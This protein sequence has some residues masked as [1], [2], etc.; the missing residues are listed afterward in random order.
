MTHPRSLPGAALAA[1]L[2]ALL[3]STFTGCS[4]TQL[5]VL[6]EDGSG[7]ATTSM[8]IDPVFAAY[9]NDVAASMGGDESA[10]LFDAAAIQASLERQPGVSVENVVVG[11]DGSLHIE[12]AFDSIESLLR[13]QGEAASRIVRFERTESFRRLAAS[14]DRD[15]VATILSIAGVD[16]F[17]SETLLPPDDGMSAAEYR[18]YLAWAFEE[19]V[20]DRP[21][22]VIFRNSRVET[23]IEPAGAVVQVRGGEVSDGR[24][25]FDT[26]LVEAVT[27]QQPL[28][29]ALVYAPQ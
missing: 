3:A 20:Q 13:A 6:E 27:A 14:V 7:T 24:V 21:L 17:V 10:P 19:Y 12:L 2:L 28:Q 18:D 5:V 9:L 26:P 15:A 1:G 16:P 25:R 8:S 29:Y 23:T 4:A 11:D 22:D